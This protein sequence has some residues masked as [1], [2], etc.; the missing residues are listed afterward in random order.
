MDNILIEQLLKQIETNLG[1]PKVFANVIEA[2][3]FCREISGDRFATASEMESLLTYPDDHGYQVIE[4]YLESGVMVITGFNDT[5]E[6]RVRNDLLTAEE[7]Q[8]WLGQED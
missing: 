4:D 7:Y 3:M 2:L 6:N 1:K 8:E 5:Y